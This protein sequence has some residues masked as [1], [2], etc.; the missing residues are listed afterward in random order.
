MR[1]PI[2]PL[3]TLLWLVSQASFAQVYSL[4]GQV[5]DEQTDKPIPF[6][7]VYLNKTTVGTST[8]VEGEFT[9]KFT[10]YVV[11]QTNIELV[12]SCV[13]YE[14]IVYP[15]PLDQLDKKFVFKLSPKE[16]LLEEI[17]VNAERDEVWYLNLETFQDQFL[18]L[19][20]FGKQCEIL[21]INDLIIIFREQE[22]LL[23]VSARAPLRI[24]NALLGYEIEYL[25]DGFVFNTATG[26][27]NFAGYSFFKEAQGGR[28]KRRRWAKN[29]LKAYR[30]SSLHFLKSL[31][32]Q[33]LVENGFNL[34][35]LVRLPNPNR[36]SEE[37]LKEFRNA[38]LSGGQVSLTDDHRDIRNRARLP[39]FVD[40]LDTNA[41][42]YTSYFRKQDE[43]G[44]LAFPD[45]IQVVY[46]GEK[47]EESYVSLTSPVFGQTRKPSYQTSVVSLTVDSTILQANGMTS[48]PFD[49]LYE[50][51]WA[52]EKLGEM[53]PLG[54]QPPDE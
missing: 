4:V 43:D 15:L 11:S 25:L 46:T 24:K 52:W 18:G 27:V 40:Y 5:L 50:G 44:V 34:R 51:Y 7:T 3:L 2:L 17:V 35:R 45:Y 48:N 36:P 37:E 53:L 29:R 49:L 54:Y 9:L 6:S 19:S 31:Y 14:P 8:S 47:E 28:F 39:E 12:V 20:E 32:Q 1:S 33:Q 21:N 10:P 42:A 22:N 41:L 26:R 38:L 16:E 13:G 30:G 23:Q